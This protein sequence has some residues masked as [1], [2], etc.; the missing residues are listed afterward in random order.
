[1]FAASIVLGRHSV[2]K[3]LG[4]TLSNK[5][6]EAG[7]LQKRPG[8]SRGTSNFGNSMGDAAPSPAFAQYFH[9]LHWQKLPADCRDKKFDPTPLTSLLMFNIELNVFRS[10]YRSDI[11][12][13]SPFAQINQPIN[14][15]CSKRPIAFYVTA[16]TS[17]LSSNAFTFFSSSF[18]SSTFMSKEREGPQHWSHQCK[19]DQIIV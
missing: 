6:F 10:C 18:S 13:K 7:I 9:H 4:H 17:S 12:V 2:V 15:F 3:C 16:S 8:G 11:F 1:M 19:W 14:C 5:K